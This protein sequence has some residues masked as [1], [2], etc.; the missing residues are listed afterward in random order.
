[1]AFKKVSGSRKYYK[2]NEMSEGDGI[3]TAATYLGTEQGKYGIEHIFE[4]DDAV[5]VLNSAGHLNKLVE[6]Y[7]NPGQ[8]CN[9]TYAGRIT[10]DKGP[11]AG[12]DC[13]TFEMEVETQ[14]HTPPP[15]VVA[16]AAPA[17]P[18]PKPQPAKLP[19]KKLSKAVKATVD[20]GDDISL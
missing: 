16:A 17:A 2:Y 15:V 10:L 6:K 1:M 18:T 3:L 19:V 20:A 7:L 4:Q 9:L 13:H 11:M 5:H 8:R 14:D 12:K